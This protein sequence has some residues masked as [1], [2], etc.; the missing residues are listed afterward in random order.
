MGG[1]ATTHPE[2][3]ND[4]VTPGRAA[5][6]T[7]SVT[8]TTPTTSGPAPTSTVQPAPTTSASQTTS[9]TTAP[10][11]TVSEPAPTTTV[12][13]ET[14]IPS[15]CGSITVA[16]SSDTIILLDVD[17][18]PGMAVDRKNEGSESVEVSFEG[19]GGHCEI[20]AEIKYGVL[21]AEDTYEPA[22]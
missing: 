20:E 10:S 13:T 21:D 9:S 18:N 11:T 5:V 12:A 7:T 16:I 14:V 1:S 17:P 6:T 4:A 2:Q 8:A 22:S 3:A 19:P 15:Q